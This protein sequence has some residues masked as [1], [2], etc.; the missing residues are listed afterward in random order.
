M[1]KAMY[2]LEATVKSVIKKGKVELHIVPTSAYTIKSPKGHTVYIAFKNANKDR[3]QE[4]EKGI[5]SKKLKQ[6]KDADFKQWICLKADT[7]RSVPFE[8]NDVSQIWCPDK[9]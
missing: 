8:F 9:K 7:G 6:I 2:K 1:G 5:L 4:I 3:V